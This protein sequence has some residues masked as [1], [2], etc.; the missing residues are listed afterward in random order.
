MKLAASP[1][2]I[3]FNYV[4]LAILA[5][6]LS[7]VLHEFAHW[8]VGT[9]LGNEMAMTLNTSYPTSGQFVQE[10]DANIVSI[11]GPILTILQAIIFFFM[12]RNNGS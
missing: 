9:F 2:S 10:T 4:L 1:F 5:V 8:S 7:W 11:A 3:S 6:V 12:L